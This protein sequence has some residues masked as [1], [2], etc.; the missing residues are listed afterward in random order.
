M[1]ANGFD[2]NVDGREKFKQRKRSEEH[3]PKVTSG[4]S[5]QRCKAGMGRDP[6][7]I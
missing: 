1:G 4:N 5:Q 2:L 3:I 7:P 6:R